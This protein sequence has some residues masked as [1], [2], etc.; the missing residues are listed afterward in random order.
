MKSAVCTLFEGHYHYGVGALA[1][2][3]YAR[4]FRGTIYAG[5]RGELPPWVRENGKA[6]SR[7][8]TTERLTSDPNP[9]PNPMVSDETTG[10]SPADGLTLRFVPLATDWHLTNYKPRFLLE[11]FANDM[12]LDRIFYFDPDIVVKCPW[13]FFEDWVQPGVALVEEIATNGMP[14]NHP[15]RRKWL[16][17]AAELGIPAKPAF[18]QYFNGGFIG[19]RRFLTPSL[20]DWNRIMN[21]LWNLGIDLKLFMPNSRVHPFC[22]ADQDTMNIF[23]MAVEPYLSTIGPEGMDFIPGGF[24]MSH[25]VGGP[26][27]WRK[28]YLTSAFKGNKPTLADKSFWNNVNEPI[29][30]FSVR[31]MRSRRV[32][33]DAASLI[34]RFYH[35]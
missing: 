6:E 35:R 9:N 26:K 33:M 29:S 18:S 16:D 3:L 2:S 20:E 7:K 22:S 5:Y 31:L 8:Q 28:N 1:N 23:A 27:P 4:G 12:S 32:M 34:G 25:A 19:V 15:L 17:V 21:H 13:T 30:L 14:Y 11:L 24:T 10:F